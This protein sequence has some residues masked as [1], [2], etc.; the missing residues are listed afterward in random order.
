LIK[1][2]AWNAGKQYS[3]WQTS[4]LNCLFARIFFGEAEGKKLAVGMPEGD[5]WRSGF[6]WFETGL[7]VDVR[8]DLRTLGVDRSSEDAEVYR[9]LGIGLQLLAVCCWFRKVLS[10]ATGVE[11]V[12]SKQPIYL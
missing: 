11:G 5:D 1:R 8:L 3:W 9:R 12:G 2:K 4:K 7:V 6:Q 10:A